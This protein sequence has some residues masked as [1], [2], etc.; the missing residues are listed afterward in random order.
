MSMPDFS[1]L[2]RSVRQQLT[3]IFDRLPDADRHM[4]LLSLLDGKNLD[5]I[6]SLLGMTPAEAEKNYVQL[7]AA[8]ARMMNRLID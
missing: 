2:H 5:Q 4:L 8:L 3:D 7:R 6:A 1:K